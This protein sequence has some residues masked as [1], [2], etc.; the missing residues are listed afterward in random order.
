MMSVFNSSKASSEEHM[1]PIFPEQV[2]AGS[3]CCLCFEQQTE[4][5]EEVWFTASIGDAIGPSLFHQKGP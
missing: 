5:H 2:A 4:D 3:D 1:I